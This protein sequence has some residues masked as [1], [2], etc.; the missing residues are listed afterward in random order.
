MAPT[1]QLLDHTADLRVRIV[2]GS[3]AV[4]F[5]NAGLA[6]A[7]LICDPQ[8]IAPVET[9]CIDVTGDD[10]PDLMVNYL[11]ELLYLWSGE[12]RLIKSVEVI[13]IDPAA[14]SAM[15]TVERYAPSRH[16]ILNEIK[17]VTYHQIVVEPTGNGWQ[18][19]VVFDI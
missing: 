6:L 15:V 11:R 10:P 14:V 19:T 18:A 3:M 2:G 16:A 12:E 1:Y 5:E 9:L 13:D 7:D 8:T 17:A 4:L